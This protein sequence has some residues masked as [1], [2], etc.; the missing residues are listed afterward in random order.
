VKYAAIALLILIV[1]QSLAAGDKAAG[2]VVERRGGNIYDLSTGENLFKIEANIKPGK[3]GHIFF[4]S[5]YLDNNK[6][7][8]MTEEAYFYQ[9]RLQRYVV[10]QNQLNE[11]YELK[12]KNN[13]LQ[14]SIRKNGIVKT[15]ETDLPDNLVIGPSFVP[16]FQQHWKEIM[17]EKKV[18]VR[19]AVLDYM[20][21]FGFEFEKVKSENET[22]S[23][24]VRMRATSI[25]V[26]AMVNP[27]YFLVQSDGSKIIEMKGRMLVK[28]KD[29]NSL[30][31]F[32][33]RAVFTY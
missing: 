30:R 8:V 19:L 26:A 32:E 2:T 11:D 9:M 23:V 20:D 25:F 29:G 1:N 4:E 10:R 7:E 6:Q 28:I 27:V 12:V 31:D 21:T 16:F 3:D 5:L 14:F 24:L 22:H 18:P 13:K 17:S 33:G 15:K